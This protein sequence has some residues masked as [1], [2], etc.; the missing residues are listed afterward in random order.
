MVVKERWPSQKEDGAPFLL[1]KLLSFLCTKTK[2]GT[3]YWQAF[4]RLNRA[5]LYYL[6]FSTN[7]TN[8]RRT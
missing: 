3:L 2:N 7:R 8:G 5:Y 4:I 1:E 6:Q